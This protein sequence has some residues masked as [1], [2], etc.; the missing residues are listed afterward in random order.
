MRERKEGGGYTQE[1]R[2]D[3]KSFSFS[4]PIFVVSLPFL[5]SKSHA[6]IYKLAVEIR[7]ALL[8]DVLLHVG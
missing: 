5:P 4:T 3:G 1:G 6:P 7:D 2:R 8:E